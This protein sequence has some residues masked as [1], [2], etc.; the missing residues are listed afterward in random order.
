MTKRLIASMALIATVLVAMAGVLGSA[1]AQDSATPTMDGHAV[2]STVHPAHIHA[3]TCDTLGD[4]VFPLNDV[5]SGDP[6]ATPEATP[7]LA[8]ASTP[9]A[10]ATA[11]STTTVEVALDDIISGGHAI[12]VHESAEN[13][14]NYIACGDVTGEATGGMLTVELQELNGSGFS[15]EAMLTDNG[16][17]TTTVEIHLMQGGSGTATPAA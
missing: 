17:G 13:I 11:Q 14:Q 10:D 12:N 9:A 5:T 1:T 8:M 15:G 3:G 6:M 2:G 16:D 7:S 4:V